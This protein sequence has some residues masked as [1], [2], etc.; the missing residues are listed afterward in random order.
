[1]F[2]ILYLLFIP[3]VHTQKNFKKK[4]E[5]LFRRSKKQPNRTPALG[6]KPSARP[7]R[8][9]DPLRRALCSTSW[10]RSFLV[11]KS[12]KN[13]NKKE[14]GGARRTKTGTWMLCF[15][16]KIKNKKNKKLDKIKCPNPVLEKKF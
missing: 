16:K 10:G 2:L 8:R 11:P 14:P 7:V 13:G 1:V 3:F 12:S 5:K 4:K 9:F 15:L 6:S